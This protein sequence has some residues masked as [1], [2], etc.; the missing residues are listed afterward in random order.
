MSKKTLFLLVTVLAGFACGIARG[1]GQGQPQLTVEAA[2]ARIRFGTVVGACYALE[3]SADLATGNWTPIGLE[4]AGDGAEHSVTDSGGGS[5]PR[6]FYR[7]R[8][9]PTMVL[10]PA[11]SFQMGNSM[12]ASEGL[13]MELPVHSVELSAF[14]MDKFMVTTPSGY[15]P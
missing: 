7:V 8:S 1:A 6:R 4:I 2:D 3:Q 5:L 9:M 10:I 15:A 13:G 11:G 14:R 12:N